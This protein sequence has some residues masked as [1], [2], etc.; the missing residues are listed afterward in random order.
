MLLDDERIAV[1]GNG[2]RRGNR[3]GSFRCVAHAAVSGQPVRYRSVGIQPLEQIAVA[4]NPGQHLV[5]GEL[6]QCGV[7]EL[8]PGAWRRDGRM[9]PAT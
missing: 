1:S 7:V 5:V 4:G 6:T 8:R 9:R 2:F 3:L